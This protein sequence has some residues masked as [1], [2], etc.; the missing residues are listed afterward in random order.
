MLSRKPFIAVMK[1]LHSSLTI[2]FP[3]ELTYFHRIPLIPSQYFFNTLLAFKCRIPT[4]S[5]QFIL[6]FDSGSYL[7]PKEYSNN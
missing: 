2:L 4:A 7:T 6:I 1:F 5:F 3:G